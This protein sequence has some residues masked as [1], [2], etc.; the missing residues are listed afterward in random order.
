MDEKRTKRPLSE[1]YVTARMVVLCLLVA[2]IILFIA[3]GHGDMRSENFRYLI[4]YLDRSSLSSSDGFSTI[5]YKGE[6]PSFVMYKGE[7]AVLSDGVL[8]LFDNGGSVVMTADVP[9][10]AEFAAKQSER[11]ITLFSRTEGKVYVY[12]AF[13]SVFEA[14][15]S[16]L[17]SVFAFDDGLAVISSGDVYRTELTLYNKNFRT[18]YSLKTDSIVT[19]VSLSGKILCYAAVPPDISDAFSGGAINC[20]EAGAFDT[21]TGESVFKSSLSGIPLATCLSGDRLYTA[22]TDGIYLFASDGVLERYYPFEVTDA[23]TNGGFAVTVNDGGRTY[24]VYAVGDSLYSCG[25]GRVTDVCF[26][27]YVYILSQSSIYR[28]T[29]SE[30]YMEIGGVP[31]YSADSVRTQVRS[32]G[33]AVFAVSGGSVLLCGRGSAFPVSFTEE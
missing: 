15:F 13:S 24:L 27:E 33:S 31:T 30:V 8:T 17:Y 25:C 28:L 29:E 1:L 18:V 14:S 5:Y 3:I 23:F 10:D 22:T 4:R 9:K 32:G 21:G 11:Y 20:G 12:N 2:F 16:G 19:S 26:G 7:L 6:N